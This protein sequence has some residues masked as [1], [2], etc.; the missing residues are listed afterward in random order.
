MESSSSKKNLFYLVVLIMTLIAMIISATIAYFSLIDS[1]REEGTVLY[2]G[3]LE[4]DYIDGVYIKD[5]ILFP[6]DDVSFETMDDV[7]RNRFSVKS[8]GTL[9]QT[10]SVDL[11]ITLNE[12]SPNALKYA[13]YNN[14]GVRLSTGYVPVSGIVNLVSNMFL[15]H[16][17]T[18][19]YTL[20]IWWDGSDPEF[21]MRV[22]AGK[23]VS[24]KINIKSVQVKNNT[25]FR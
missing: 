11:D 13:V 24:G 25:I 10:I 2:T 8:S 22:D 12:F 6:M 15:E 4:I 5:P 18:A 17:G 21:D 7:Y 9:D 23:E 3:K 16:D 20:I 1:Q 14:N 19:Y